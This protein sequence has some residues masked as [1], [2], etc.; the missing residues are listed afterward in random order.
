MVASQ[1]ITQE[2][3]AT[4]DVDELKKALIQRRET[5]EVGWGFCYK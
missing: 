4:S 2:I 3:Y 1:T 5:E